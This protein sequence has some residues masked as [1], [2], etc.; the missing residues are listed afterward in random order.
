[1]LLEKPVFFSQGR[2]SKNCSVQPVCDPTHYPQPVSI[3]VDSGAKLVGE[4]EYQE[5]EAY[6]FWATR[7]YV[8]T[9]DKYTCQICKKK[10][11]ILQTI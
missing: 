1:V 2:Q 8:F 5:S 9:R 4:S 7:Y 3:G 10:G 11:G 6:G